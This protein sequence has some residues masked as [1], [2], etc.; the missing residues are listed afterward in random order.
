MC[1]KLVEST[2]ASWPPRHWL[3]RGGFPRWCRPARVAVLNLMVPPRCAFCDAD[4]ETH[5]GEPLLCETCRGL[6]AP[7]AW[8]N[9][10]R[11]GWL[12]DGPP[13][14]TG[15][16]EMGFSVPTTHCPRCQK[17]PYH[18]DGV[19][20]LGAY[21]DTLRTAVLR[22]KQRTGDHLA[23]VVGELWAS[24]R[25]A[26]LAA[27][28]PDVVVPIPMHW[29]RHVARGTNSPEIMAGRISRRLGVPFERAMLVRHRKTQ[30]QADL[31]PPKRFENVRGAF[32]LGR[33][34]AIKD[35]R[36][37]LVDD[38]MTTGATCSEAARV[39]KQSGAAVVFAAVAART[40]S[41]DG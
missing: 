23:R 39:L 38:I 8:T 18:F 22:M 32:R 41:T 25:S 17:Q 16:G 37:L 20:P 21:R 14:T 28:G 34:Y 36:V 31:S 5:D 29:L 2:H 4:I 35:A 40:M 12:T 24:R 11:C 26:E 10:H 13:P 3:G 33:G 30:P 7:E 9:C 15:D 27:L 6:L 1:D 19:V